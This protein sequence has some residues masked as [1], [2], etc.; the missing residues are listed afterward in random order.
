MTQ[1]RT[2][3]SYDAV[4]AAYAEALS[5]EPVAACFCSPCTRGE[6]TRHLAKW[7]GAEVATPRAYFPARAV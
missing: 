4:A 2:L 5:D 3:A 7:F 1:D 6:D